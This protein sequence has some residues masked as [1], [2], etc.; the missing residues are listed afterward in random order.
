MINIDLENTFQ[1]D[2]VK[3]DRELSF[4]EFNS[5]QRDGHV[6]LIRVEIKPHPDKLLPTVYNLAMGPLNAIGEIDD[7]VRLKHTDSNKLFST[8]ILFSL[9]FLTDFSEL[10]IGLDGTDDLRANLYHSMFVTN[11]KRLN[12]FFVTIGVDWYVKLL[13]NQIEIERRK[14]G[15]P[16]F[17]PRPELFDYNRTRHD[18]YRYYMYQLKK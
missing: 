2:S 1:P 8:I 18:L 9:V 15:T 13:R 7:I 12:E 3:L 5:P 11:R 14:D 10:T 17:K 16:F 6:K 4:M